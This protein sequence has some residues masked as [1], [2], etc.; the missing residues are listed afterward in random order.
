MNCWADK[1]LLYTQ[2]QWTWCARKFREG[3]SMESLSRFLG[4]HRE[5]VRRH[6]V[7][8]GE[9]PE[10]RNDLP[11]LDTFADEFNGLAKEERK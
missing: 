11:T 2:A 5:T 1:R 8:M 7:G 3:Y 6:L 9:I 10:H 4:V